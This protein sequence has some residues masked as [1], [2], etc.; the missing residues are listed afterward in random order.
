MLCMCMY[1]TRMTESIA[2]KNLRGNFTKLVRDVNDGDD[3][4]SARQNTTIPKEMKL[5]RLNIQS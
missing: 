1:G 5:P 2:C 4:F 3:F